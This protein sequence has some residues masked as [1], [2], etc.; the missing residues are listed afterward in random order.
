MSTLE[1][2]II[3]G[4]A[5]ALAGA[6]SALSAI[7]VPQNSVL[8]YETA[9]KADNFVVTAQGTPEQAEKAREALEPTAEA[10]VSTFSPK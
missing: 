2:G 5:G 9:L 10:E 3:G 6:L 8:R 1:G 7:G 4:A